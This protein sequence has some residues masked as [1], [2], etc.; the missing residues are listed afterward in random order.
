ME[1]FTDMLV[2]AEEAYWE[3]VEEAEEIQPYCRAFGFLYNG[4]IWPFLDYEG[5]EFEGGGLWNG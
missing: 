5:F 4:K 1:L 3:M 2:E